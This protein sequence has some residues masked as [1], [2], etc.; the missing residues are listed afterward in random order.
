[1]EMSWTFLLAPCRRGLPLAM[2]NPPRILAILGRMVSALRAAKHPNGRVAIWMPPPLKRARTESQQDRLLV[3][4]NSLRVVNFLRGALPDP[5]WRPTVMCG[6]YYLSLLRVGP[7]VRSFLR[8]E[9]LLAPSDA[10]GSPLAGR[11]C[12]PQDPFFEVIVTIL[13]P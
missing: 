10:P 4:E 2:W 5:Q 1:M 3:T 11:V 9:I 6:M 8:W 12:L 7:R 13:F